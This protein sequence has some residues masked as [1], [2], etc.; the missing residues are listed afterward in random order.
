MAKKPGGEQIYIKSQIA[1]LNM[2]NRL[3]EKIEWVFV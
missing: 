2:W 1:V 3:S